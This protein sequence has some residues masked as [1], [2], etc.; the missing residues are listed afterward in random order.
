MLPLDQ[1]WYRR[2]LAYAFA[3]GLSAGLLGLGYLAITGAGIDLFFGD[4]TT[5]VWSGEWWWIPLVA[6]GGVSVA[7]LRKV[8]S[9]PD[10]TP[11]AIDAIEAAEI[12]HGSA[13]KLVAIS[14]VSLVVGAS[15]GPSFAL[16]IMGGA[17]GSWLAE[18]K[19]AEGKADATYTLA[20]MAGG[21]G[22]AFT[23]PILGAFLVS[24]L[25][26]TPRERY[27]ASIIPQLISATVG[28]TVFYLIVG[29]VFIQSFKLPEYDFEMSHMLVAVGLGIAAVVVVLTVVAMTALVKKASGLVSNR[30]VL[31]AVGGGLI[32]L[33]AFAMPLTLGSGNAQLAAI[34]ETSVPLG[35]GLLA[36]VLV[37]KMIAVVV[38]MWIGF[39]GGNVF[40]MIFIGG[41]AGVIVHL[42][43]PGIP[44]ALTVSALMAA[45]PG[46]FLRAPVSL[47]F[48]AA[49]SVGLGPETTA[50]VV[51]SV[52]TAYLLVATI[53]YFVSQRMQSSAGAGEPVAE[54]A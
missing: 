12:D 11:G 37:A 23:A 49:L 51:V 50:P 7:A 6:V 20:G 8:W 5:E 43:F 31:G 46:S 35:V 17:L 16:V 22:G 52:I 28:F 32:G 39:V 34:L 41:T 36:A 24:E 44:I 26:P 2:L 48:L 25:A 4:P 42:I 27:V 19:W 53:R 13:P 9:T 33:T 3:L 14:A 54:G 21:L 1:P 10:E 30:Y 45:V 38:S 18:R 29:Q 15:L 47:T 40:P